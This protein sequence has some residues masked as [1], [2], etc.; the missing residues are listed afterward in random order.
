MASRF[1][2]YV[3]VAV[4]HEIAQHDSNYLVLSLEYLITVEGRADHDSRH[5]SSKQTA[6][7]VKDAEVYIYLLLTSLSEYSTLLWTGRS[8]ANVVSRS[9]N[10]R[11]VPPPGARLHAEADAPSQRECRG[12][13]WCG[14]SGRIGR[15]G[16]PSAA[17]TATN[18]NAQQH[19]P[20]SLTGPAGR[21]EFLLFLRSLL[22]IIFKVDWSEF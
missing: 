8:T 9:N 13:W 14:W 21:T 18:C 5:G 20:T 12:S 6:K 11:A 1:A 7:D 19:L 17:F 22:I 10:K 3:C 15:R 2:W 4:F 16:L